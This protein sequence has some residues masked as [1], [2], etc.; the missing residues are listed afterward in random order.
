MQNQAVTILNTA[1]SSVLTDRYLNRGTAFTPDQR[2]KLRI[3][4]RLPP[5]V[6]TLEEQIARVYDQL[7]RYDKPINRYQH[8]AAVHA[9]NTTLYYATILAH[10]QET[11]PVIYTP[12]VGEACQ[13][14]NHLFI[15][16]RGLYFNR[17]Y[18]GMFRNIMK[19]A[20]Y[21][22]VDIV[23]I[24]DGSRILGLG[25]LGANGVGISIG[26]CSLY[27]AGAG[28]NPQHVVPVILDVGTN[29]EKYLSDKGY[30][31]IRERRLGDDDFYC[32][33]DEFMDA[34]RDVWPSAVVQFEDFSNNHCFG[35]LERYQN[36][37]RCFND[38]IQGTGAVIAAG[39]LNAMQVSGIPVKD[40]RILFLGAGSAATGVAQCIATLAS[41]EFNVPMKTMHDT[42]YLVDSKGLVTTTRGDKLAAHKVSWAR[43]DVSAEDSAKLSTLEDVVRFVKPTALIG[44]SAIGGAFTEE[45]VKFMS[46]YC[47]RPV[48]FPLSNPCSKAEIRPDDAYKW[49]NGT[50]IVASGSPFPAATLGGKTYMP[51]QGNNLYIFP[52]VGLG[53]AIAQP[54]YIPQEALNAAASALSRMVDPEVVKAEGTLYPPIENVREVSM[55]VAVAVIEE[56]QR[57]GLAKSDLPKTKP[58]LIKLVESGMWEPR[59]LEPEYYLTREF[60]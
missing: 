38:D 2:Q 39:F 3:V 35:M 4:G 7:K 52:G 32:L 25:D 56:L 26:K 13:N 45:I 43:T 15:R 28:I 27:V 41:A 19:E 33:L 46:S 58:E 24:T 5:V 47:E 42:I 34:A 11:L 57:M 59:Y 48:L 8:L 21:K 6:E 49:T 44:L 53:C 17:L 54:P 40:Q 51:S 55:H 14:Y 10:L 1:A 50:A 30:L 22:R 18:K 23:V 60:N 36:K 20:A 12:T 9:T 37:Y 16:E 31:G 29:N